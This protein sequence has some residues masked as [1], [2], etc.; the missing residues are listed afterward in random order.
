MFR[1]CCPECGHLLSKSR[2]ACPFCEWEET[3]DQ[4]IFSLMVENDLSYLNSS[5][6]SREQLLN[7]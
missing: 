6:L 4:Y 2:N 3:S 1:E 7:V 5:E